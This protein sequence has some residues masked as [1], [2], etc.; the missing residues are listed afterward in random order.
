MQLSTKSEYGLRAL[1]DIALHSNDGLVSL[2]E[3]TWRQDISSSYLE[4]LMLSLQSAGMVRSI[5]GRKGGFTLTKPPSEIKVLEVLRSLERTLTLF[6]CVNN[7]G[8]CSRQENC[9]TNE[10][11]CRLTEAFIRELDA[12][13]LEDLMNWEQEKSVREKRKD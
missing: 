2:R 11:W 3:I 12:Y 4:Q 9:A 1:L 5:R 13:T 8:I 7:P 6:D 10:L